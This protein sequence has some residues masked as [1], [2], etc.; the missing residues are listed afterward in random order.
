MTVL[1]AGVDTKIRSGK[2][3]MAAEVW[4]SIHEL[5]YSQPRRDDWY[6]FYAETKSG[7]TNTLASGYEG[8]EETLVM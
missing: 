6:V 2:T 7:H 4:I 5:L 3:S 1:C 8:E